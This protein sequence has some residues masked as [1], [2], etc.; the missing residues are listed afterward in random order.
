MLR[1]SVSEDSQAAA[2]AASERSA[3]ALP[4][5][6]CKDGTL[7]NR[8]KDLG[9]SIYLDPKARGTRSWRSD[10]SQVGTGTTV[11]PTRFDNLKS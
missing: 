2:A 1:L 10:G 5:E 9:S 3:R 7:V 6:I 11:G 4:S 8:R